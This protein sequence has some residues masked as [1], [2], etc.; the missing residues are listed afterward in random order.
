MCLYLR[1]LLY[2]F[3]FYFVVFN[4]FINFSKNIDKNN[5]KSSNIHKYC[6]CYNDDKI[7]KKEEIINEKTVND[8]DL[9]KDISRDFIENNRERV[10]KM[11]KVFNKDFKYEDIDEI[12]LLLYNL[13]EDN[14]KVIMKYLYSKFVKNNDNVL[15]LIDSNRMFYIF[16]IDK[17]DF[18]VQSLFFGKQ[19]YYYNF[20]S[21][22]NNKGTYGKEFDITENYDNIAIKTLF[23]YFYKYNIE[24]NRPFPLKFI[25]KIADYLYFFK[26]KELKKELECNNYFHITL[27]DKLSIEK[28]VYFYL[29][30]EFKECYEVENEK[31]FIFV[32]NNIEQIIFKISCDKVEFY[33][34]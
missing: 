1:I 19:Y 26:K 13:N 32:T 20:E 22:N 27:D 11:I 18:N 5:D 34:Y 28:P 15:Y 29:N 4:N 24:N 3:N 6:N 25:S 23:D 2:F 21:F 31:Q 9:D 7:I 33:R 17:K 14:C 30:E 8:L 16:L 12:L 10:F